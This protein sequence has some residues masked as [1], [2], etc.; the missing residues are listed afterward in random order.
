MTSTNQNPALRQPAAPQTSTA[1][2][3]RSQ[4][5]YLRFVNSELGKKVA[6]SLGLPRPVPLRRYVPGQPLLEGPAVLAGAGSAPLLDALG[7]FLAPRGVEVVRPQLEGVDGTPGADGE[8]A[9]PAELPLTDGVRPAA[10]VVDMTSAER[11]AD[12]D[13]LRRA[14][15]ATLK[16]LGRSGRVIVLGATPEALVAAGASSEQVATAQAL[17]GIMRSIGKELRGGATANLLWVDRDLVG[18]MQDAAAS[19]GSAG[20]VLPA[21]LVEPLTFLLSARSAYVSGQP[22]RVR[23]AAGAA[24]PATPELLPVAEDATPFVGRVV[25]VTGAARGIGADIAR[26]LSRDGATVVGVDVPQAG[27]ALAAVANEIGGLALQL[28]ITRPEAGQRIAEAVARASRGTGPARLHAIVHN[29]GITRDKLLVNTDA[30]R[31]ASV[32]EVNLA[33]QVRINEVLLSGAEGGLG[34]GSRIVGVASTSG[35]GGNRG[36]SNY[37]ASKAGVMG[38][39]RSMAPRLAERGITVN[40]VA[41]GFIETEMTGKIPAV[42]REV[43]RRINS[44]A[45][46]G[47]PVD[48][49]ETIAFLAR[50]GND[51]V[52][53]QVLRVCGQSQLGA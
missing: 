4:D 12:L 22:L 52:T 33:A 42:T 6:G 27:D 9:A 47:L 45:Q 50:P 21:E 19:G 35:I 51:G 49:A 20:A 26:V 39:V 23:R 5:A 15:R 46:G 31:W 34:E 3:H 44:M 32:L 40:A 8:P 17:E 24:R 48:V 41:P 14:A 38:L 53:G 11:L 25:V 2:L 29:A 36:Q 10:L 30:A 37:A 13:V 1:R 18:A 16:R 28:D 7:G 43:G